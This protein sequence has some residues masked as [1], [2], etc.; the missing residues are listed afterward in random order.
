[1]PYQTGELVRGRYEIREVL[2]PRPL[3]PLYRALD[4]QI[5]VE[6]A[7]RV[8]AADLLPGDPVRRAFVQ[9]LQRARQLQ[10]PNLVRLYDVI[11]DGDQAIL[12]L[13][14]APGERLSTLLPPVSIDAQMP[15]ERARSILDQITAGVVHAHQH[16]VVLAT[17]RTDSV[18]ILSDGIKLANVG[19]GAALPR[20]VFIDVIHERDGYEP[21]APEVRG[22][23]VPT[24]R[25]DVYSI[26]K[27]A[28][29]LLGPEVAARPELEAVLRR[30]LDEDPLMRPP[31]AESLSRDIAVALGFITAP[32]PRTELELALP[33][34][35]DANSDAL[36]ERTRQVSESELRR[37][38]GRDE[39]RRVAEEEIFPL[40]VQ[41]SD[42]MD[43]VPDDLEPLGN[44]T[45]VAAP[46]AAELRLEAD[47]GEDTAPGKRF[48]LMEVTERSMAPDFRTDVGMPSL[49]REE[50]TITE[51]ALRAQTAAP[52][53]A[54]PLERPSNEPAP[55]P[56]PSSA[57][58]RSSLETASGAAKTE[59]PL[60][61]PSAS[62]RPPAS[63]PSAQ[64]TADRASRRPDQPRPTASARAVA[65][66]P[67]AQPPSH[68]A[69]RSIPS[70]RPKPQPPARQPRIPPMTIGRRAAAFV[71]LSV[72]VASGLAMSILGHFRT[73]REESERVEK[74][75]LVELL[76]AQAHSIS[77]GEAPTPSLPSAM[78]PPAQ[79]IAVKPAPVSA[80]TPPG[81][82]PETR[83]ACPLGANVVA[84]AIPYCIDVYEY[85]GGRTIPRTDVS[86]AEAGRL[87]A[88]RGA[89]L[90]S[91]G[92]WER[93]CRGPG[94]ASYPYGHTYDAS[95]CNT[96]QSE[97]A[98]AEAGS[99]QRCRSSVGVYDMSGNVAEWVASGAQ[100]GGSA[101]S[102]TP[103]TRCSH[104]VRGAPTQGSP[105]VGFRCCYDLRSPS[106]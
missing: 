27:I 7:L 8:I 33:P 93:A 99:F 16:G 56:V 98:I 4:V 63:L 25:A 102:G 48:P 87:C 76:N 71:L 64:P 43:L 5:G 61:R 28:E 90:C 54:R 47:V 46:P 79:P 65:S 75:R 40:R 34:G 1:L 12:S 9:K 26:A 97:L 105:E 53:S 22:G 62:P 80:S 23:L 100:R 19:I 21:L 67:A 57:P 17:V 32:S 104:A 14:W 18:L 24:E 60:V 3:G 50:D 52:P 55:S 70:P 36:T 84:G 95:R 66:Q 20:R 51:P 30:A 45:A 39:T 101:R 92:E 96:E 74:K 83:N 91:D 59:P 15:L 85:P 6:V 37:I 88:S 10:H 103:F 106:R 73:V 29:A 82:P 38:Q 31:S 44:E 94:G 13:Q 72:A 77:R 41:S 86:L 11:L 42:T 49:P 2:G 81:G 78:A 69:S 89:R 35:E 58:E 68:A